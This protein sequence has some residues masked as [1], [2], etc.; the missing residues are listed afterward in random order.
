M[1]GS[2]EVQGVRGTVV[3]ALICLELGTMCVR[4]GQL[5][6]T[7][8]PACSIAD[9]MLLCA[10]SPPHLWAASHC[11][12]HPSV[13]MCHAVTVLMCDPSRSELAWREHCCRFA[14]Q[15]RYVGTRVLSKAL[16]IAHQVDLNSL[17]SSA[18]SRLT[19]V[20]ADSDTNK[21]IRVA[22]QGGICLGQDI[23]GAGLALKVFPF[24][25]LPLF[26]FF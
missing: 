18:H 13:D 2:V 21:Q 14:R 20:F 10:D 19:L 3:R 17:H 23:L 7:S 15:D 25:F 24:S 12:P 1:A 16:C 9:Y 4:A 6:L 11:L 8:T 5:F 26:V 22:G